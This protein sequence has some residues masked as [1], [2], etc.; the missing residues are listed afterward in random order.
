MPKYEYKVIPAPTKGV[1]ARGLKTSEARFANAIEKKMNEL[2][3]EGWSYVRSD[4]LPSEE[5]QGLTSS[6][7]VYR[8]L[9]VFRR[10]WSDITQDD[11]TAMVEPEQDLEDADNGEQEPGSDESDETAE[12][13]S[14]E[15]QSD[16]A[17]GVEEANENK[18][19]T[20]DEPE[21]QENTR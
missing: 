10:E 14:A 18:L 6:H 3:A 12:S 1:K 8:S 11:T 15:D 5:R 2:A 4:L 16:E 20:D 13:A 17:E 21:E 19:S 7:T 9:L